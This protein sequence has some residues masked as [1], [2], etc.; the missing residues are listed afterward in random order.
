MSDPNSCAKSALSDSCLS[1]HFIKMYVFLKKNLSYL[2]ILMQM[3][4]LFHFC[5]HNCTSLKSDFVQMIKDLV[6]F[7]WFG[8]D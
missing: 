3:C 1:D 6:T 4:I 2:K 8:Q 5:L 7:A